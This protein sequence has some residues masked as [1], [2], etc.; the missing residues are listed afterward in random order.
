MNL[1]RLTRDLF[2]FFLKIYSALVIPTREGEL[3]GAF[4]F[5][6]HAGFQLGRP[7]EA[8]D[9]GMDSPLKSSIHL[10]NR[11]LAKQVSDG[12][13]IV[14]N[15]DVTLVLKHHPIHVGVRRYYNR[16]SQYVRFEYLPI[17]IPQKQSYIFNYF[18]N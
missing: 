12:F 4:N 3:D 11:R 5:S 9:E 15:E 7:Q 18:L 17:P 14:W 13:G 10:Q 1:Y 2:G 8:A 16:P 6:G